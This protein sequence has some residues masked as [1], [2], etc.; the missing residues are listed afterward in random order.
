M[1]FKNSADGSMLLQAFQATTNGTSGNQTF[2][3][4]TGTSKCEQPSKFA[5]NDQVNEFVLANMD[6]L[7]KDIAMGQGETLETLAELLQVPVTTTLAG[8]SAFPEDHPLALGTAGRTIGKQVRDFL[9]NADAVLAIG[10]SLTR[11]GFGQRMPDTTIIHATGNPADVQKDV[12]VDHAL[13]GDAQLTLQAVIDE[14]GTS[15]SE[16]RK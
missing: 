12:R 1:L 14:I 11:T 10:A 7:A 3:V 9:D 4:T 13:V 8:K 2:G 5:Q 16:I 6:N 15:A